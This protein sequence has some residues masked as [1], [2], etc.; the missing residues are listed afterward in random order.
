MDYREWV[1]SGIRM[2]ARIGAMAQREDGVGIPIRIP[3]EFLMKPSRSEKRLTPID[4][5]VG[6]EMKIGSP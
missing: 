2:P 5:R 3:L 4:H 1:S 6:R